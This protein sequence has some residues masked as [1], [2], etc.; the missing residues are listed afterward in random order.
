MKEIL[1][2]I[3]STTDIKEFVEL[4]NMCEGNVTVYSGR[5]VVD[6][7]SVMGIFSLDLSTPTKV[8]I[9]GTIPDRVKA[10]MKKFI[11]E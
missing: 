10:G 4:T 8:E 5:Y 11:V 2:K 6:G 1:V 7:K 3:N 9:E